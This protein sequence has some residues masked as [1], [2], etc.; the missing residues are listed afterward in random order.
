MAGERLTI[1]V[2]GS[3]QDDGHVRLTELIRQLELVNSALANTERIVTG[4]EQRSIYF[5]VVD[6]SHK[7]P[8]TIVL[9]P[10]RPKAGGS[11]ASKRIVS[12]F[13]TNLRQIKRG[14]VDESVDLQALESY[15]NL[16]TLLEKNVRSLSISNGRSKK[17]VEIDHRFRRRLDK[18]I[19]PD[20]VSLGSIDGRLEWLN[21]HNQ[22]QFHIYPT[23]GPRKVACYFPHELRQKVIG[24]IDRYV[25]VF[26]KLR[27]KQ[28]DPFAYAVDVIDVT[29]L[30]EYEDLPTLGSLRGIAPDATGEMS[31]ADFIR[32]LRD[33]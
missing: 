5:R 15:R 23:I 10:S 28:R 22:N 25:T 33:E 13:L 8:V 29:A 16:T 19:G 12:S 11:T 20:D 6:A 30:P 4:R 24:A 18:I 32:T 1:Q 7:S 21:I 26:G 2:L 9:E 3:P 31:A 17:P 14:R 27:Y